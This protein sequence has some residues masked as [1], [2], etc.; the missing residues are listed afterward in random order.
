LIGI[1]E[2]LQGRRDVN[3]DKRIL[4]IRKRDRRTKMKETKRAEGG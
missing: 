4:D 3:A 2:R 1:R